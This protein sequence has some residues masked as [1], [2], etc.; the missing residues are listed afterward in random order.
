MSQQERDRLHWLKLV[1][2]KKITQR[3]AAK[4]MEVS[5]PWV[6]AGFR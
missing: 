2:E 5:Q 6:E 4:R 3:Q 1:R